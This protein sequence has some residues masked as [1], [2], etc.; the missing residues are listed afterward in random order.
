MNG[1]PNQLSID[2]RHKIASVISASG[3]MPL[4]SIIAAVPFSPTILFLPAPLV[5]FGI[6]FAMPASQAGI[7][8]AVPAFSGTASGISSC[9]QLLLAAVSCHLVAASWQRPD[10]ALGV[11]SLAMMT[12]AAVF[13]AISF[14]AHHRQLNRETSS[15]RVHGNQETIVAESTPLRR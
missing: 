11:F 2:I 13:A 6:G 5:A 14:I 4:L 10:V 7:V 9:L 8:G 3:V 1:S 12:L 15:R